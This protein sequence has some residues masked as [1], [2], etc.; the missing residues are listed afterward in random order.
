M[1]SRSCWRIGAVVV[2]YRPDFGLLKRVFTLLAPQIDHIV[3]VDNTAT[4]A[5]CRWA[6]Q[7]EW[8]QKL[9]VIRPGRNSGV[10]FAHNLGISWAKKWGC[11]HLLLMDQDSV[12]RPDMVQKLVDGLVDLE[13][14]GVRVAAVGPH[15]VDPRTGQSSLIVRFGLLSAR[16]YDCHAGVEKYVRSDFL[17]SS[18]CL[19]P[20]S[21]V[22]TVGEMDAGLFIDHVDTEWFLRARM[23]GYVVYAV[24][25]AVM[26]HQLG[27]R[28]LRVWLGRWRTVPRHSGE[29]YY[30]IFRNS[31][32]LYRRPYA[33]W[34]WIAGDLVR[35]FGLFIICSLAVA[36]RR[37][38]VAMMARGVWD[39]LRGR[40]GCLD[41]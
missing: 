4:E 7:S 29:R 30:Y 33:P 11:T 1:Q 10:G 15:Y 35:L 26:E 40:T 34:R 13:N 16:K 2:T 21:A 17:I 23:K 8:K 28:P 32:L 18:G 41:C 27:D 9:Q 38:H 20:L 24:C 19:I 6:A 12:P 3:I 31:V 22:A 39:G 36:P 14:R 5:V 37:H 25:D